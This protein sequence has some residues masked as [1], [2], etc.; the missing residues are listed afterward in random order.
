MK[1]TKIP[2]RE[3]I[4]TF[5]TCTQEYTEAWVEDHEL[6]AQFAIA[7][8]PED[9]CLPF[10]TTL[11]MHGGEVAEMFNII[12][13]S[14]FGLRIHVFK[15]NDEMMEWITEFGPEK[16][17]TMLWVNDDGSYERYNPFKF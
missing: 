7:R 4:D 12:Q 8:T 5:V 14:H 16:V 9:K 15:N 3:P 11:E 6:N 2:T 1:T 17:R 13:R 10:C